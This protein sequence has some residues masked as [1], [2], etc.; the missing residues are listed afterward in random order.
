VAREAS[1]TNQFRGKDFAQRYL[2]G[3]VL[4]VGAGGDLVCPWAQGFDMEHGDANVIDRYFEPQSFDAVHSS[5]CLE[6]MLDPPS[7]LRNWWSLVKPG[8]YMILVVPDEDLY[9]QGIWPSAFNHD[10][11]FTFR[12]DQRETWSPVSFEVR[13]LCEAL[14][15]AE[16]VSAQR[17]DIN[18]DH[19]LRFP[20]GAVPKRDVRH[21]VKLLL[22]IGKRLPFANGAAEKSIRKWM[23]GRGYPL[24]Q[25]R[26]DAL[27]QIQVIVRRAGTRPA[28]AA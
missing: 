5:H 26:Y 11:K 15:G 24:D 6:H 10:H 13:S 23:L 19:A 25:T 9:E 3:K 1:K 22:S 12:L 20:P 7:A 4:D 27:A 18:Y 16:I 17:Q 2:Q 28:A 21:P 8:G 14:D